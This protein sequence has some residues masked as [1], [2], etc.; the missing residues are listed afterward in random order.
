MVAI[1]D[2]EVRHRKAWSQMQDLLARAEKDDRGLLAEEEEQYSSWNEELDQLEGRINRIREHEARNLG[3]DH[4]GEPARPT[5][6][7]EEKRDQHQ[8]LRQ[9]FRGFLEGAAA[10]KGGSFELRATLQADSDIGGGYL[11]TGVFLPELLKEID[12]ET[13]MVAKVRKIQIGEAVKLGVPTLDN[14]LNDADWTSELL[15]GTED[16]NTTVGKRELEPHPLA[17]LVKISKKLARASAIGM[18]GFLRQRLA[19][20]FGVTLEKALMTGSGSGQPLGMFTASND[21]IPTTRDVSTDNTTTSV[22]GDGLINSF[23]D[24]KQ[25]Y[26]SRAELLCHRDFLKQVR[27]LKDGNGQYLWSPG[28][29]GGQPGTVLDRPYIL[30]EYAPNTFT[31]GLYVGIWGVWEYY[32]L[33]QVL[34]LE[35]QILNELYATTNQIGMIGRVEADGAPVLSEAFRRIKLA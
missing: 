19:Y 9:Q 28:L 5:P 24:L 14:D 3:A 6:G 17:K 27:K 21:G 32:W 8:E 4:G 29:A 22:T 30:S 18:E 15:T 16:T 12:N 34:Q 26:Q 10:G 2:L 1:K 25:Q 33:V 13:P 23:Y 11:T 31:T 20:V 7:K 35:L